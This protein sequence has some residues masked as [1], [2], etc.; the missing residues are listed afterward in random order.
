MRNFKRKKPQRKARSPQSNRKLRKLAPSTPQLELKIESVGGRGDGIGKGEVEIDYQR[1]EHSV[2][3]PYTLA[4][5]KVRC[6]P[7]HVLGEGIGADLV[8]LIEASDD[9]AE[10]PCPH[11]M[12]CGGCALQHMAEPAYLA[13]KSALVQTHLRRAG[14]GETGIAEI[15]A[16]AAGSR[17]RADLVMRNSSGKLIIGFHERRSHRIVEVSEC[18]VLHPD[19][20]AL[21]P[22]M[23]TRLA[24]IIAPGEEA[25]AVINLVD[26]GPDIL[27]RLPKDLE[28]AERV[29]LAE[30][31]DE[32]EISRITAVIGDHPDAMEP[33]SERRRPA[34]SFAGVS[35]APP[36]GA[37]LQATASGEEAIRSIVM[38]ALQ[39]AGNIVEFFSGIGTFTLPLAAEKPITAYELDQRAVSAAINAARTARI[40]HRLTARPRNLMKNPVLTGDLGE[41]DAALLDPPR[42]GAKAQ[43]DEI[44]ASGI[45]RVVYVSCNPATFARDAAVLAGAGFALK[46]VH[47]IDQFLWSPHVE[48]VGTFVRGAHGE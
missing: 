43:I 48:L 42:A 41:F 8:E 10:P 45:G 44:A 2:F 11:F 17:R 26:N 4:G 12:R 6:Q 40:D 36:P 27:L 7:V 47:P 23:R 28:M 24:Q 9:R 33:V 19:I 13:W 22:S 15:R 3:V 30:F 1:A 39:D 14:L 34:I 5:E 35:C 21:I 20:V 46:T 16:S 38:D 32:F 37:F 18:P 25:E 31:A 29:S